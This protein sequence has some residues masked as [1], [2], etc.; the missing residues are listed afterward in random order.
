MPAYFKATFAEFAATPETAV[1]GE[2]ED[3]AARSG[4][5]FKTASST[6]SWQRQIGLLQKHVT[7]LIGEDPLRERW[8]LLL[9][10]PIP[11]RNK[12]I[13]AV[14]LAEGVILCLEFKVTFTGAA[15]FRSAD[16]RQVE[17]YALDLHDFHLAS[18][19]RTIFPILVVPDSP[20]SANP[21]ILGTGTLRETI[22]VNGDDLAAVLRKIHSELSKEVAD[23]IAADDWNS[24]GYMP[25]PTIIE[26]AEALFQ[27]H[28]VREIASSD[29]GKQNLAATAD[30][31]SRVILDSQK[32]GTRTV[33][34]ITGVPGAGKTLAG[35]NLAHNPVLRNAGL[36]PSVFL[37]GNGPL[38]KVITEAL[39]Q[40]SPDPTKSARRRAST[41]IQNVHTYIREGLRTSDPQPESVVVF[42]EAQR[43]WD[44]DQVRRRYG[45]LLSRGFDVVGEEF[46]HLSEPEMMLEILSRR[47][48]FAVLVA[49]VGGGQEINRGESGLHEWGR[50]LSKALQGWRVVASPL[51][52]PGGEGAS[53]QLLFD[54]D[55][56]ETKPDCSPEPS[57]HLGIGIRSP[58]A[59]SLSAWVDAV[60]SGTADQAKAIR[61]SIPGF[62]LRLT[63]N[64]DVAR[65]WTLSKCR[66]N[67][68]CGLLASAS[69]LRLRSD[70]VEV[71]TGFRSGNKT[72]YEHWFLRPWG[73][74]RSSNRL[75]VAASQYECQGLEIDWAVV[76]WGEDFLWNT[77][78]DW[79][80]S[81]LNGTNRRIVR[82]EGQRRYLANGYRVLLTRARF[83]MAIFVP[84]GSAGDP[85]RPPELL[86]ATAKFLA[87]CGV[88][89]LDDPV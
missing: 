37:T 19:N 6:R 5:A 72:Q 32:S 33:C 71:S 2:L 25:V 58:R 9:E 46:H 50:V 67:R 76:C 48:D 27:S 23:P 18:A 70:G 39:A 81:K 49:L 69:A 68:R 20:E 56:S 74:V 44:A 79:I 45:Q 88:P 38:V 51:I 83:G 54:G 53:G 64:I 31:L 60:L 24:S 59:E 82:D 29:S 36:P 11:R 8:S 62:P 47:Q 65:R 77:D 21:Q 13:D 84:R 87:D 89:L 86:D 34:F 42:D 52:L 43:A 12:R 22:L 73:D 30:A 14:I 75:E 57:F 10:F 17:D 40:G 3:G 41:F 55:G 63:R 61:T 66:G 15:I 78:G 26:A 16:Q 35:L 28:D 85:T 7:T 4:F 80:Y 1:L